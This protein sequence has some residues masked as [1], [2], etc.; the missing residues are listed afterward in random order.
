LITL[1]I[2]TIIIASIKTKKIKRQ[3]KENKLIEKCIVAG[4][5][6]KSGKNDFEYEMD[7]LMELVK[8]SGG[9]VE[10]VVTQ[11]R[12]SYSSALYFGK[13]KAEEIKVLAEELE[14]TLLV[15]NDELSGSQINN[16]QNAT[17]IRVIDRTMLILDIFALRAKT[18]ESKLQVELAQLKYTI[19]R[20]KGK[21]IE[22]S[23]LGGGIGTRGPGEKKLE[24]DRRHIEQQIYE[25]E[26][27]LKKTVTVREVNRK[28]RIKSN[29][30]I[31]SVVGYTNAGKSTLI[32][33]LLS[34]YGVEKDKE[35]FTLDQVFAT[36]TS[37]N[38]KLILP[39][40]I[41]IIITD[42]VGFISKLPTKLVE[43]FKSTLEEINYSDLIIHLIDITNENLRIQKNT[44]E[45]VLKEIK[46]VDLPVIEV[47]NKIDKS[48]YNYTESK[49]IY[50][51]AKSS[52]NLEKL[53]EEISF[54]L[55][56]KN[57][58]YDIILNYADYEKINLVEN[59]TDI[60]ERKYKE[61]GIYI[62]F[63]TREKIFDRYF[64]EKNCNEDLSDD[65]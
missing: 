10:C 13:G 23:R 33:T 16:L 4:V 17:D 28:T 14:A 60:I 15:V 65:F 19:P 52:L 46:A 36:L 37:E 9:T 57:N 48:D 5:K 32:N 44:T 55:Y 12:D 51:S 54:N 3:V 59:K 11:E 20:L 63:K 58:I 21:G 38:R 42:T 56:G 18:K 64:R 40:K 50:I 62:K 29:I 61:D 7:E 34:L 31:V 47:F 53:I 39:G 35:L 41:E 8:A 27:Q 26:K 45:N 30:P 2:Y 43:S 1:E 49:G 25:L 24:T 22:M 6:L